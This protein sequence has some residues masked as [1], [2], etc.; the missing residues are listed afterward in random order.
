[1]EINTVGLDELLR[2]TV[3]GG[4]H[5]QDIDCLGNVAHRATM[6][7]TILQETGDADRED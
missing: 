1:M 6:C 7:Y 3:R 2:Q 5:T 4:Q